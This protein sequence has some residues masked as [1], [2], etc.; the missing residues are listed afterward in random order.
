MAFGFLSGSSILRTIWK[1]WTIDRDA[2]GKKKQQ[3]KNEKFLSIYSLKF[4]T[5]EMYSEV[6]YT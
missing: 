2:T 3:H 4:F 5:K 1:K 6:F